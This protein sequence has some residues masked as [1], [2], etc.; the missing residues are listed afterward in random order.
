MQQKKS[1]IVAIPIPSLDRFGRAIR[2]KKQEKWVRNTQ[3]ELAQCF[4]GATA[5]PAPGTNILEGK[6]LYEQGQVL[7]LAA[8]NDRAEFIARRGK[9]EVLVQRMG[10][11]LEQDSVFLL[12]FPSDSVLIEIPYDNPL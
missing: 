8:C 4:G 6:T 3:T 7:V 5:I 2:R 11:D 9:L 10:V 12:A 1:Y